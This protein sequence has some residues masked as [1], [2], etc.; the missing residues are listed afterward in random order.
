MGSLEG[1]GGCQ[2]IGLRGLVGT[3][4]LPVIP[5]GP[6]P[7]L[8]LL[9]SFFLRSRSL[10]LSIAAWSLVSC[11]W[12]RSSVSPQS[13][14]VWPLKMLTHL[15]LMEGWCPPKDTQYQGPSLPVHVHPVPW[16]VCSQPDPGGLLSPLELFFLRMEA[17]TRSE[18]RWAWWCRCERASWNQSPVRIF[19]CPGSASEARSLLEDEGGDGSH[20]TYIPAM[21]SVP[22]PG[23]GPR[24]A[25][26]NQIRSL[27]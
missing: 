2:G 22:G 19:S 15:L 1:R 18:P 17:R 11:A 12:V 27:L 9:F 25:T 26:A 14:E 10:S 20:P 8:Q 3:P 7:G 6:P 16:A 23:P 4:P 5:P 21:H 24:D 13:Q